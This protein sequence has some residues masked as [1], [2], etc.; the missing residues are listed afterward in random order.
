MGIRLYAAPA[1]QSPVMIASWPGIG[2][3]GLMAVETL[4]TVLEAEP[5]GEI[6]PWDF[7]Y[8]KKL[9]IRAGQLEDLEFPASRFYYKRTANRDLILFSGEEQPADDGTAYAQGTS[10]YRL[11]SMVLDVAV[12]FRC[13]R[14]YT[15]GAAVALIHHTARSRVWAVP[16]APQLISEIRGYEN[17]VL[18]SDVEGRA[19]QGQIAGLNGLLLGAAR[20][21]G[22]EAICVMGEI[23]VYLQVFPIP[24]PKGSKSVLEV[25]AAALGIRGDFEGIAT[26]AERTEKEIDKLCESL[27]QEVREQIDRLPRSP[28]ARP[29]QPGPITEAD[30]QRILEDIDRF[31]KRETRED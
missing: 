13:R 31:F 16:N 29:S 17:T 5:L 4:R 6:E 9:T 27:P 10:A 21:R 15:S 28:Q 2:N 26:V 3:I 23:P 20:R 19:G 11:A 12:K 25:L 22:L 7:F 18:M 14:V 1:L 24:Y 8:P 30:K